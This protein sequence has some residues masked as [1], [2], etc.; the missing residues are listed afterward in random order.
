MESKRTCFRA[1]VIDNLGLHY[2]TRYTRNRHNVPMILLNHIWQKL[3]HSPIVR[4][5]IDV[6]FITLGVSNSAKEEIMASLEL[7]LLFSNT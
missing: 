4:Q 6:L 7:K 3:S 5:D 1:T 2:V